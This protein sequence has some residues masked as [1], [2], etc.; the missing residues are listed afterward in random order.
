MD[1]GKDLGSPDV[2][3]SAPGPRSRINRRAFVLTGF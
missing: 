1:G 2:A 3:Q